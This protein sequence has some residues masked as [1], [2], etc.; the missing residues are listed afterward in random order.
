MKVTD[1][2]DLLV[3]I[4]W[5]YYIE[6]LT[7]QE[8]GDRLR[9]HGEFYALILLATLATPMPS[10]LLGYTAPAIAMMPS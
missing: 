3:R 6:N 8:I 2:D 5:L 9:N 1:Q 7:Q 10:P 4:A